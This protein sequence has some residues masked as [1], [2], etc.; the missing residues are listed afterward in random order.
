MKALGIIAVVLAV[1][2]FFVPV[3]GPYLVCVAL[4]FAS[5]A[6]FLGEKPLTIATLVFGI[7]NI[8]LSP[9]LV[10]NP[11]LLTPYIILLLLTI[12]GLIVGRKKGLA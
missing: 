5:I 9:T 2:G 1:I 11:F 4:I 12:I 3:A 7:V 6:A 8:F 10:L